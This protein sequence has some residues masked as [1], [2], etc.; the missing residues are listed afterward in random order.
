MGGEALS[1]GKI[2]GPSTGECQGLEA[3]VSELRSRAGGVYGVL[4]IIFEM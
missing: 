4:G 2:I 1:L 3:V